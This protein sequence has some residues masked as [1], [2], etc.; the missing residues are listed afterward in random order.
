MLVGGRLKL[1]FSPA[2]DFVDPKN[3]AAPRAARAPRTVRH[4]AAARSAR[5]RSYSELAVASRSG[6]LR[7]SIE[8]VT[9]E[10]RVG[11]VRGEHA[12]ESPGHRET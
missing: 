9:W 12:S 8:R 7:Q 3:L 4:A 10:D 5:V 6:V 2:V 1:A 11:T